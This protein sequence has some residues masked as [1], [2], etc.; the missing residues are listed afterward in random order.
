MLRVTAADCRRCTAWSRGGTLCSARDRS[1]LRNPLTRN[2]SQRDDKDLISKLF[3]LLDMFIA[4]RESRDGLRQFSL[5]TKAGCV[6]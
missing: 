3:S 2:K 4:I 5:H 1:A 6:S